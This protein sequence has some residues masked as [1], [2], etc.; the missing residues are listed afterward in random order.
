MASNQSNDDATQVIRQKLNNEKIKLW[1]PPYTEEG[2][3]VGIYP[4]VSKNK[5]C[6]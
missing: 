1:L 3:T 6:V 5:R 2:A 4:E